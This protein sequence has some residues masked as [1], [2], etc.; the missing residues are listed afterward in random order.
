MGQRFA[1]TDEGVEQTRQRQR[2]G[3]TGSTLGVMPLNRLGQRFALHRFHRIERSPA[4]IHFVHRHN[5]GMLELPGDLCLAN[6]SPRGLARLRTRLDL[7]DRTSRAKSLSR[8]SQTFP[9]PSMRFRRTVRRRVTGVGD[10]TTGRNTTCLNIRKQLSSL[11]P[12]AGHNTRPRPDPRHT[13]SIGFAFIFRPSFCDSPVIASGMPK[14]DWSC[15][16]NN[17]NFESFFHLTRSVNTIWNR[18][19]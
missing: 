14:N 19:Q 8:A 9:I 17:R 11:W 4:A 13:V 7:L 6:Q 12:R 10:H 18:S 15:A 5:V 16:G 2:I 3:L 1:N